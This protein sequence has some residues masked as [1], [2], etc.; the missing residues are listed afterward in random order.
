[1]LNN[2]IFINLFADDTLLSISGTDHVEVTNKMNNELNVLYKW[3]CI[4]KLKLNAH[5]T[6]CMIL[7]SKQNCHKYLNSNP[8]IYIKDTKIHFV[9]EMKYLGVILDQQLTLC[10]HVDFVCKKIG[11]KTG[12][13]YRIS[14]NLSQW[15]KLLVYNTIIYPH[16]AYCASLLISCNKDT[17]NRMQLLQN[18]SMRIILGCSKYTPID[19]MRAELQWLSIEDIIKK[20]NLV[21]IYKIKNKLL[22]QYLQSFLVKRSEVHS[23]NIRSKENFNIDF[24]KSSNLQKTLFG[25]GL[26][27]FNSLPNEIKSAQNLK[28]FERKLKKLY[29]TKESP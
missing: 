8:D 26:R 18:K 29:L 5:K 20:S 21:L 24:V 13:F 17:I 12:F 14:D 1:M 11:K 16:I 23:Y 7:G 28:S 22:P 15:C 4:N 2:N 19:C 27:L 6:K 3:L 10:K 25:D 9:S